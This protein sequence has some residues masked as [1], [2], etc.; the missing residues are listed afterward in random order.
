MNC[1][2]LINKIYIFYP[3]SGADPGKEGGGLS[4]LNC[5]RRG[6]NLLS[7]RATMRFLDMYFLLLWGVKEGGGLYNPETLNLLDP[8]LSVSVPDTYMHITTPTL[9]IRKRGVQK[10]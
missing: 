3:N 2:L 6:S 7:G 9:Q 4:G 10:V 8:P 5:E 1:I